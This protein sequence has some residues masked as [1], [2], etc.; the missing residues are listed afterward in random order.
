MAKK[1]RAKIGNVLRLPGDG[2]RQGRLGENG[3]SQW[4]G[5]CWKT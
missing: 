5:S 4:G 2:L 1:D 3:G